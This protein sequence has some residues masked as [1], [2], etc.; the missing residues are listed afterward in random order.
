M[1]VRLLVRLAVVAVL[2]LLGWIALTS[3]ST[4]VAVANWAP[5][6]RNWAYVDAWLP[7][8]SPLESEAIAFNDG[9]GKVCYGSPA[10]RGRSV[11][12]GATVP[13]GRLWRTG[14]NEPTTL[15][16]SVDVELGGLHLVPGSYSIYTVPGPDRWVV[17]L[18]RATRQWGHESQYTREVESQEV[19]RFELPVERLETPVERFAIRARPL[20]GDDWRL[21]LAWQTTRIRIPLTRSD[22]DSELEADLELDELSEAED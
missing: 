9:R 14:A 2:V 22:P 8:A 6:P 18:N 13:Y 19:G 16:L 11:L 12:G 10:L 17:I 3:L 1:V 7:R 21:D 15:H 5:C 20:G 4:G